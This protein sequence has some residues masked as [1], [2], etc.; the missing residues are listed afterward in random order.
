MKITEL[1]EPKQPVAIN[2][3]FDDTSAMAKINPQTKLIVNFL[4]DEDPIAIE[5]NVNDQ[6]NITGSGNVSAIFVTV[7]ETVKQYVQNNPDCSALYFTA[8]EQSRAKMYDTLAKR[9]AKQLGW[10]V[11][12]YDEMASDEKFKHALDSRQFVFAI[13]KGAAP[14]HRQAAQKPQHGEFMPIYYVIS[15]ETPELFAVKIKA[16][17]GDEAEQW[18]MRNIPEYKKEDPFGI[19]AS[20]GLPTGRKIID[21]GQVPEKPKPIPQDPNSLGAKLRAKLDAK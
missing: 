1:F 7:I 14:E 11:V 20:R 21:K 18:V 8:E 13:E 12:P 5:F 9:V 4:G 6:F 2:W 16:K 15:M 10:H 17:N 19:F 3:N